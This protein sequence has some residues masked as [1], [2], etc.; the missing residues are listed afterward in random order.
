MKLAVVFLVALSGLGAACSPYSPDLGAAPFVCGSADP[1][2]PDGYDCVPAGSSSTMICLAAG[3]TVPDGGGSGMCADDS[4]LEPNNTIQQAYITPVEDQGPKTISYAGLA[5]CPAGDKDTYK[6]TTTAA[7]HNVEAIVT[8][9]ANGAVLTAAILNSGGTAIANATAV[10]GM[11]GTIRAY[12]AMAPQ[13]IYYV[14]V[15][16]PAT[17]TLL[18]NNYKLTLTVSGQ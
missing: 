17:G 3:G 1:K 15:S 8:Y 5:I 4:N 2:C 12:V 11:D 18:T 6:L 10:A 16:G 9:D 14:Q 7:N 13:G